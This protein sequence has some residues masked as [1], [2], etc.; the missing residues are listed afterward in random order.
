MRGNQIGFII[1]CVLIVI[2]AGFGLYATLKNDKLDI[3][4]V[5][6]YE[7]VT[8]EQNNLSNVQKNTVIIKSKELGSFSTTI[9][10]DS[11]N[12]LNNIKVACNTL[13]GYILS[14]G[15]MFSFN[16]VVGPYSED[17][18][19][20][21][22]FGLDSDGKRIKVIGGGV[23]QVSSTLYNLAMDL[24]FDI[25]ERHQ[26]SASVGYIELGKDATIAY[27]RL[28]LK[29]VNTSSYDIKFNVNCD[30]NTVTITATTDT[31]LP[32]S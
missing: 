19:Y 5:T 23:C 10:D 6:N 11:E 32:Q 7:N 31:M 9:Y 28:D 8:I 20:M 25:T 12:R 2:V 4:T 29:F 21:E 16:E 15:E 30:N 26:H 3:N 22:S 13:N 18:G 17:K 24:N 14:P 27:G 1:V